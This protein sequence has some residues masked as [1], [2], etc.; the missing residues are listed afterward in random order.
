MSICGAVSGFWG[1]NGLSQRK[2]RQ[3]LTKQAR[4]KSYIEF[5]I[6]KKSG[7]TRRISSPN[8]QLKRIQ[9][10]IN[11]MLQTLCEVSQEATGFVPDRSIVT[12]AEKHLDSSVIFNCDLKDFFPSI[13]KEMVRKSLA[14]ELQNYQVSREVVNMLSSLVTAPRKDGVEALPQGAPTSPVVSN[15]VLKKLDRRLSIFAEKNGYR[16]SRYADDITFS[17]AGD[18]NAAMP[19][20]SGAIESIIVDSGFAINPKKSVLL[21]F[22][23]RREVTGLTVGKKL[24]VARSYVKQLRVLLYLWEKRGYDEAQMIYTRDFRGGKEADLASVINGKINYLCMVKGREDSTYR[25]LKRRYRKLMKK[26]MKMKKQVGE[27]I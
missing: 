10:C 17:K 22:A 7:G 16:Y 27:S 24:N 21:T 11:L 3:F 9:Q 19:I 4:E 20:K 15:L 8:S 2:I 13:T 12:N 5:E 6:P 23:N 25:R 18:Y 1:L 14:E 26:L